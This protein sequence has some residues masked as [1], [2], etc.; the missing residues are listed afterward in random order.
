M[1]SNSI[2]RKQLADW[3]LT[4]LRESAWAPLSIFGLYLVGVTLDLYDLIPALDIPTHFL[5][6]VTITYFYRFT[7]RNSQKFLGEIPL[8]VRILCAFTCTGTTV[9]FWEFYE[10][11][12]DHFLHTQLVMGLTDSLKDMFLGLSGALILTLFYR[13]G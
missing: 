13:K 4:T 1:K 7:L 2:T 9:V 8:P 6:G 12:L 10:N 3:I 5:G 11:I